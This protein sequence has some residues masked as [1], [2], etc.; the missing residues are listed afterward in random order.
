M[1]ARPY[2]H[3]SRF[4]EGWS[5]GGVFRGSENL[6]RI[7]QR[8][9]DSQTLLTLKGLCYYLYYNN[10]IHIGFDR[11]LVQSCAL[12]FVGSHSNQ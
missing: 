10:S 4:P 5:L 9:L 3:D 7:P 12:E 11:A 8:D 6:V 1:Y 2:M